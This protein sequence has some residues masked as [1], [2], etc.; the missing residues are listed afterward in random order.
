MRKANSAAVFW[1]SSSTPAAPPHSSNRSTSV[2][3]RP[4]LSELI[5][6]VL[7]GLNE[8][9]QVTRKLFCTADVFLQQVHQDKLR[10]RVPHWLMLPDNFSEELDVPANENPLERLGILG[11]RHQKLTGKTA[12]WVGSYQHAAQ[13]LIA[14]LEKEAESRV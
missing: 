7:S 3:D 1:F 14:H 10:E 4:E 12:H 9:G 5:A 13:R 6:D 11:K 8:S 2:L